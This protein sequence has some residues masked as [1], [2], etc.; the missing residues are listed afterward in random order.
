MRDSD[1]KL[2]Q[3]SDDMPED[4]GWSNTC[5]IIFK[6]DCYRT[7]HH[8]CRDTNRRVG[9]TELVGRLEHDQTVH[10]EVYS[11]AARDEIKLQRLDHCRDLYCLAK[12]VHR[13]DNHLNFSIDMPSKRPDLSLILFARCKSDYRATGQMH[14]LKSVSIMSP[15]FSQ[16]KDSLHFPYTKGERY[17]LRHLVS[18][19]KS[20]QVN[21]GRHYQH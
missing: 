14:L 10:L 4:I 16:D 1:L 12:P 8:Y 9:I 5:S 18:T 15:E 11:Y 6:V 2:F 17:I 20:E 19:C 13:V 7:T 21:H 3:L